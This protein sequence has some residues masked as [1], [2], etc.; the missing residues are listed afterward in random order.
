M[1]KENLET[2]ASFAELVEI[3]GGVSLVLLAGYLTNTN[4]SM[5]GEEFD[6]ALARIITGAYFFYACHEYKSKR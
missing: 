2:K 1:K 5:A 4:F 3:A 6:R